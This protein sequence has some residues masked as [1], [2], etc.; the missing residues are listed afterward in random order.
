MSGAVYAH[1]YTIWVCMFTHVC[2]C[3]CPHMGSTKCE[4]VCR[5]MGDSVCVGNSVLSMDKHGYHPENK[6]LF[7]D[8]AQR[9]GLHGVPA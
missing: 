1:M 8:D 5:L 7:Q 6:Q 2:T 4:Q 9:L 3:P